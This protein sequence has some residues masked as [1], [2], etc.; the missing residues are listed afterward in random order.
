MKM[1]KSYEKEN[2]TVRFTLVLP[3]ED[4]KKAEMAV[5]KKNKQYFNIPG[6]RKGKAPKKLIENMYGKDFFVEDAIN[7]LLPEAYGKK[8]EELELDVIDQPNVDIDEYKSGEDVEVQIEVDV[9]PD[10]EVGDY[11]NLEIAKVSEEVTDEQID[12]RIEQERQK[13]ARR[14]NIDDRKAEDGD[15][16]SI[17]Y[18]GR[19]DGE[20]FEGGA[21]EDQELELGSGT[22]IPGFEE[23]IVGK[24][25]GETFDV[26]V[27]FPEKYQAKELEGKDAVFTVTLK[28]ISKEELPEINDDFVM[29]ISEFDSLDEYKD[30]IREELSEANKSFARQQKEEEL[31]EELIKITSV[32]VPE[33]MVERVIDER[34]SSYS[35]NFQQQGISMDQY[36]R[37]LNTNME[38]FRDSLKDD[39]EKVVIT[40]LAMDEIVRQ[41]DFDV[42]E[43]EIKEEA[44]KIAD[45]YFG[46][47][48]KQKEE[49]I[50]FMVD[51][52]DERM[53]QDL[54]YRKAVDFLLENAKEVEKEKEDTQEEEADHEE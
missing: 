4:V 46:Q 28:A 10:V 17:D 18:V 45:K 34:V 47:D 52:Q 48:E 41:E 32:D 19:V 3:A 12:R 35:Q 53:K 24:E 25:I 2:N 21:A 49:M 50:K 31:M 16:V 22:F 27:T 54:I 11:K 14:I 44:E 23:Q 43:E 6:F 51:S 30:H 13:N 20:E 42:S 29:D 1:D 7:E 26:N 8:V 38:D 33:V 9:V 36:L 15:I 37:M 40:R 5:Y 39:A